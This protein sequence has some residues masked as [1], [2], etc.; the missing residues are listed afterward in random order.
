MIV[1][2][3]KIVIIGA[4]DRLMD[5]LHHVHELGFLH[6]EPDI[7]SVADENL[8]PYLKALSLDEQTVSER[9]FYEDLK[10]KIDTLLECIPDVPSRKPYLSPQTAAKAIGEIVSDHIES[11]RTLFR[12]KES[13]QEEKQEL[14]RYGNFLIAIESLHPPEGISPDL[15]YIGIEISS[16]EALA[17]LEKFLDQQTKGR[18]ELLTTQSD[19]N[20]IIGLITTRKEF[21]DQ[22]RAQLIER[23]VSEYTLPEELKS[24]SLAE[25]NKVILK[26][27]AAC[28]LEITAINEKLRS[29]SSR[30][31]GTYRLVRQ[32]LSDRLSVIQSTASIYETE[33]CFFILG[34]LPTTDLEKLKKSVDEKFAGKVVVE[35]KEILEQDMERIPTMLKNPA[36]FQPFEIFARLLPIPAYSSFDITPF[37]GIF[38]PIFF[39]MMLGD[40]GY[41]IVI[42]AIS[43]LLLGLYKHKKL[44]TDAAKILGVCGGY[45]IFF[46]ILFGECFGRAGSEFI[47]LKPIF[48]DRQS[49][50]EP[51]FY[52]A[53]AVGVVHIIIGL[54]MGLISALRKKLKKE[55]LFKLFTILLILCLAFVGASFWMPT[56]TVLKRPLLITVGIITP[57]LLVTG[58][59]MA[60]LEVIKSIGN[61]ISYARIMAIGLTSVLLAYVANHLAG[62]A[63]SIW[64]G[65][66]VAILLHAFNILLGIFAPTIHSLRLHYV[67]FFSKFMESGGKEYKP[68]GRE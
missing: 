20:T 64:I 38:F 28:A 12:K 19:N 63:G 50:I 18:F 22:L 43:L 15:D 9:L 8:D 11:C 59:L 55:A 42:L 56:L 58:G 46:G 37:I 39:G 57:V 2:M 34:W 24:L 1:R 3:S 13:L 25:Q 33:L 45:T 49:A 14:N 31:L 29:F 16:P 35:E 48:F 41:G 51:M 4:K 21:A 52:F 26:K 17:D 30:W 32:W 65:V 23:R 27:L 66:F 53:L 10:N 62:M 40:I 47:G 54:A 44:V 68:M 67:E 7:K 61:I 36:Y 5:V 6:I 60:P